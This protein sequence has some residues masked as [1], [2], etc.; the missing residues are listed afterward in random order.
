[1]ALKANSTD[2]SSSL[3]AKA[4]TSSVNTALALKANS[5]DVSSSLA[6]K[7]DTSSVNS[8]LALKAPLASPTFTGT[9]TLP[10]GTTAVTQSAGDNSTKLATTFYVD[11]S[12]AA[13][14]P[15]AT[16][17][18]LGKIRLSGDL[19]GTADAPTVPALSLKAD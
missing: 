16:N 13:A 4:D 19:A 11:R 17:T 7:A 5:S 10:T 1:L 12:V 8:A 15:D 9:P 6:A 2:V 3:A 18:T 14:T